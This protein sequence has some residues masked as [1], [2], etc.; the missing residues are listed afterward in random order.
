MKYIIL[1]LLNAIFLSSEAQDLLGATYLDIQDGLSKEGL[2]FITKYD[3]EQ[4][5]IQAE[6]K[7]GVGLYYFSKNNVCFKCV[8]FDSVFTFE[9]M[10]NKIEKAGF[11]FDHHFEGTGYWYSN[12]KYSIEKEDCYLTW[13]SKYN[14]WWT[15]YTIAKS[16]QNE[17]TSNTN[18]SNTLLTTDNL[19]SNNDVG[20]SPFLALTISTVNFRE[21][22]SLNAGVIKPLLANTQ[23][24]IFSTN[25]IDG[26]Y[27]AIDINSGKIG[28]VSKSFVKWYKSVDAKDNDVFQSTGY[29]SSYNSEVKIVNK[30]SNT[31]TLVV[32]NDDYYLAPHSNHTVYI[33]P[34]YKYYVG[35]APGVLPTSGYQTFKA[36]NGYEWTF[37]VETTK[38]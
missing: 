8:N 32:G 9:E 28:W 12:E 5:Y 24:Y 18:S 17:K 38:Y 3:G 4:K 21:N 10:Q 27:K 6:Y 34:G 7:W 36:N 25:D 13:D 26:F 16:K 20:F 15:Y 33:P 11:K 35:S 1:F 29:S 23:L 31:I 30:S 37:W 2:Y 19:K 14:G 22:H